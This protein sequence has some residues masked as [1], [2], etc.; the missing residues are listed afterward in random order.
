MGRNGQ[1]QDARLLARAGQQQPNSPFVLS[2][3]KGQ[4]TPTA[5][6]RSE[7]NH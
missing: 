6:Y 3:S 1:H 4:L 7:G 2:N 5:R